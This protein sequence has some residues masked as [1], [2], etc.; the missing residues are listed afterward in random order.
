MFSS[1]QQQSLFNLL[2][3]FS[4]PKTMQMK[5][6]CVEPIDN[7]PISYFDDQFQG[8]IEEVTATDVTFQ[9]PMNFQQVDSSQSV[10]L[11]RSPYAF[12]APDTATVTKSNQKIFGEFLIQPPSNVR[13]SNFFTFSFKLS[14]VNTNPIVVENCKFS[15]FS[16]NNENNGIIYSC[17]LLFTDGSRTKQDLFVKMVNSVSDKLISFDPSSA[18][19]LTPEQQKVLVVHKTVCSR[20]NEG[21]TCGSEAD[22]PSDPVI[23]D[24]GSSVQVFLKCNQNCMKGPGKS[25]EPRRFKI[26]ISTTDDTLGSSLCKSQILFIH[27]NS[28]HSRTKSFVKSE[29]DSK[30]RRDPKVYPRLVAVSP[31]EGWTMGG[32]TIVVIG[33]NFRP[34]LRVLFGA[35]PVTCHLISSHAARVMSPPRPEA[36]S[37]EVTLALDCHQYNKENPGTFTYNSPSDPG[38][39]HGFSRLA[40]LV[41]RFPEDPS[42]LPREVVLSRAAD[43][44]GNSVASNGSM[45]EHEEQPSSSKKAKLDEM[46]LAPW[47]I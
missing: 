1:K 8:K 46:L 26:V 28:K 29:S 33:E 16:V 21:K 18:S 24:G 30:H 7:Y 27:N 37:V 6:E 43:I 11:S 31:S 3:D 47:L 9:I 42:R 23:T 38:L 2:A 4:E 32:Q 40:R 35:I 17:S 14:D 41:P 25:K 20:C 15:R 34:G 45:R 19:G 22:N 39:D 5:E 10:V 36:G 13:K 12:E 44:L